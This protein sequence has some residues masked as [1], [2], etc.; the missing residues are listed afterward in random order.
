[1]VQVVVQLVAQPQALPDQVVMVLLD[2]VAA[3]QEHQAQQIQH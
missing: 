2:A 1:V 3:V